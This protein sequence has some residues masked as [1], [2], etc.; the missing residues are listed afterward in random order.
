MKIA[1]VTTGLLPVPATKG[2]AVENLLDLFLEENEKYHEFEIDVFSMRETFAEKKA[3][4]N[5]PSTT[6]HFINTSS[7]PYRLIEKILI[8]I[9]KFHYDGRLFGY[10]CGKAI[11]KGGYDAVIIENFPQHNIAI[12]RMVKIPIWLHT[13]NSHIQIENKWAESYLKPLDGVITVS[14]FIAG[15]VQTVADHYNITTPI[16]VAPNGI[17][18]KRF[19]K[20]VSKRAKDNLRKSL[21]ITTDKKIILF[22][23]R[24]TPAKGVK[25]LLI[26]FSQCNHFNEYVLLVIG[27]STF[28]SN[29][30]TPYIQECKSI[31]KKLG[32][33][34]IFTGYVDYHRIHEYYAIAD[35]QCVPSIWEEPACLV[36][37]EGMA[38]GLPLIVSDSGGTPEHVS[39]ECGIIVK[40]DNNY[41]KKLSNALDYV[42]QNEKLRLSMGKA[43]QERVKSFTSECYYRNMINAINKLKSKAT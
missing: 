27:A 32:D 16:V 3:K 5:Y 22:T 20:P 33:K 6:F 25:E 42:L 28:S 24:F 36:S 35:V 4:I 7:L 12:K 8:Q 15:E 39:K 38:A 10:L 43:G 21:N 41:I 26:A 34:V 40:R 2:G 29:K 14:K 31:A 13:H 11:R 18:I 37:L 9:N 17:N 30:Q 23:G 1:F 19:Q